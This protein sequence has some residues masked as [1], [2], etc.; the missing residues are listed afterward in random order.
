MNLII[1]LTLIFSSNWVLKN[2]V[3]HWYF[4]A[5]YIDFIILTL[6]YLEKINYLNFKQYKIT[7]VIASLFL[8]LSAISNHIFLFGDFKTFVQK[9]KPLNSL[10]QIGLMGTYSETY[11][12]SVI[13]P[14]MIK[15]VTHEFGDIKDS[16]RIDEFFN[17]KRKFL[18][19][20]YWLDKFPDSI[21]QYKV[22]LYKKGKPINSG[23]SSM[24]EYQEKKNIQV[25]KIKDL[26]VPKKYLDTLNNF[27]KISKLNT[28]LN[29]THIAYGPF[30]AL[31][32]GKYKINFYIDF[33]DTELEKLN[34][35]III[36]VTSD[37]SKKILQSK[38]LIK[39]DFNTKKNCFSMFF[40]ASEYLEN[41]EFRVYYDGGL[42]FNLKSIELI[43]IE[44]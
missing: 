36:D 22:M 34:K 31:T 33:K 30:C 9:I 32:H 16:S 2:D 5:S 44:N 40:K 15:C 27:L 23:V 3:G 43:P 26:M 12:L 24:C 1:N 11:R 25:F 14:N 6:I 20:N 39:Q 35:Q 7:F 19:K 29:H 10:G 18:I 28:E 8:S 4:I 13:N 21:L 37:Y 17:S 42:D 38:V 41:T